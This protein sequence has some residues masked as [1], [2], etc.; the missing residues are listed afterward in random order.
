[1]KFPCIFISLAFFVVGF[2]EDLLPPPPNVDEM[3]EYLA[4]MERSRKHQMSMALSQKMGFA[5]WDDTNNDEELPEGSGSLVANRWPCPIPYQINNG[6]IIEH[7]AVKHPETILEAIEYIG[8]VTEWSFVERTDEEDYLLFVDSEG[9]SSRIG[10]VGGRQSVN[11]NEYCKFGTV[12]HEIMHSIGIHHEHVR[13]DRD[14]YVSLKYAECERPDHNYEISPIYNLGPYDLN[15]VM[16][17]PLTESDPRV[18]VRLRPSQSIECS[19]LF[20]TR[21]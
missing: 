9:C 15:S 11:L 3:A 19:N 7:L 18:N 12:I 16:H 10:K 2:S 14:N 5:I 21:T 6:S 13:E 20:R 17:Y 1:M 8:L 4:V